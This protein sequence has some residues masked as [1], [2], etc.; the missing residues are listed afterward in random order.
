SNRDGYGARVT[1]EAG[2]RRQ[3]KECHADGS[4]FSSSDS[5]LVF[6]LGS[7]ESIESATIRWPS[8]CEETVRGLAARRYHLWVEGVGL[9]TPG[10]GR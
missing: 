10:A 6:G 7:S 5:R 2:G 3:A 4:I 8:G 1:L 9:V